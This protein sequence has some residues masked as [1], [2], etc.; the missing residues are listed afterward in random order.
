VQIRVR[1][2]IGFSFLAFCGFAA[3][4]VGANGVGVK[5]IGGILF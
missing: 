1:F 5:S 2:F 3:A 4:N